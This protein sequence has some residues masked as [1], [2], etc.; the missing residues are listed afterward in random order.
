MESGVVDG[1]GWIAKR[2]THLQSL[3]EGDASE[4]DRRAIEEEIVVLSREQ[5]FACDGPI[6]NEMPRRVPAVGESSEAH[7]VLEGS[8]TP[9]VLTPSR[10][11]GSRR[12]RVVGDS[13]T[14]P[15]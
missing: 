2:L 1:S 10:R 4:E 3:L 15:D 11:K 8:E 12:S 7:P 5:G 14:W 6:L 13:G 9:P